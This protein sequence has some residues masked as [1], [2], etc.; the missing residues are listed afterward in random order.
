MRSRL[1]TRARRCALALGVLASA[2]GQD[3]TGTFTDDRITAVC[4]WYDRCGTFE[5]AGYADIGAC[6]SDLAAAAKADAAFMNC[7][8]FSQADADACIAA[9]DD[10]DCATPP[11]LSACESVC[12]N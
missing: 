7:D 1:A 11:D 6:R 3:S 2:C 9:W 4:G 10:A 12:S 8:D 5:S